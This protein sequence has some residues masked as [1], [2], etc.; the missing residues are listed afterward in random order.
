MA[1]EQPNILFLFS[2]Q[3]SARALGCYGNPEVHTPNLDRLAA[4]GVRLNRAYAQS[5]ICTPSR[6]CFQSGQYCQ[7]HGYYGLMGPPPKSLPS[8]FTLTREAGY[9]NGMI[10][11]IHTPKDW[12]GRDCHWVEGINPVETEK[13]LPGDNP[14]PKLGNCAYDQYLS[15]K[16]LADHRDDNSLKGPDG[17]RHKQVVDAAPSRLASEDTVEGWA[18]HRSIQFIEQA[19]DQQKPFCLWMSMPRPH[20]VYSPSQEYWDRYDSDELSLP[21][22]ADDALESRSAPARETA[23][24][25]RNDPSWRIFEPKDWE[26]SRRRSLHGYYGCVTQVDAAVGEV[27]QAIER[28][29]IRENTIVVYSSD[30]GEFAGEHGILEK[31]PGIG[32]HCVTRIPMIWSWPGMLESGAVREAL[33][34][35][36]DVLPTLA[37]LAGLETPDWVDGKDIQKL[38]QEDSPVRDMAVTEHPL[39]KT[40]H[41]SRY[42]LTLFLP[43]VNDG[44]AHGELFDL[45]EDPYEL[46]NLYSIREYRDTR[47]ELTLQLYAWLVRSRRP[48]T[49]NPRAPDPRDPVGYIPWQ[50]APEL[51]GRDGKMKP[52][53]YAELIKRGKRNYL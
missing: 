37:A 51:Y 3:H 6:M 21:P 5:P 22:N 29:G 2:D 34:E 32:F 15:R 24:R 23:Q 49:A 28:L 40:V 47:E 45:Q 30:H 31:A 12:L 50:E 26:S 27:L 41:S 7:N 35:S 8:L 20:Q 17:V 43:E 52:Q 1:S 11:K 14:D 10:G 44:Q 9:L 46:H 53:V 38:L 19:R 42:K 18:A 36:V 16:G 25:F 33:T 39:S 4:E 48:I 13:P